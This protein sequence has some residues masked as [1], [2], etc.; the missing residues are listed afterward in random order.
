MTDLGVL[1]G[2]RSVARA[3]NSSGEIVGS[4]SVAGREHTFLHSNGK[5]AD[6]GTFGGEWSCPCGI[7]D[8]GKIV[9]EFASA[10]HG[11]AHAFVF[12]DGKNSDLG[13]L[14]AFCDPHV[15]ASG[16]VSSAHAINRRGQ[17]VGKATT[18]RGETHAFLYDGGKM[19]D[20][21]T[22]GG[23]YSEA[24]AINSHGQAVGVSTTS[25][26]HPH[27]FLYS[28]GKMSDLNT[29]LVSGSKWEVI[30]A[31]GINEGG[32]IAGRGESPSAEAHAILLTPVASK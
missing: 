31:S 21:G 20:M 14:G 4:F 15:R 30:S 25:V 22:L 23:K 7:N 26:G 27:G 17:I 3:I 10:A 29:L 16:G 18:Q 12:H 11:D 8:V 2:K 9:G 6:I 1:S 28:D 19:N 5:T 13:Y 32:Q 24:N